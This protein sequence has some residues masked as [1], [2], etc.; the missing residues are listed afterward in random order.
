[1]SPRSSSDDEQQ[2]ADQAQ[3]APRVALEHLEEAPLLVDERPGLLLRQD[4]HVAED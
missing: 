3:E 4:L 1:M 2:V